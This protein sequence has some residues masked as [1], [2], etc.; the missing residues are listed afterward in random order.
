M[1]RVMEELG[2]R[3]AEVAEMYPDTSGRVRLTF[4][5]PTRGPLGFGRCS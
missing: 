3:R 2:P 4:R 1:G 5:A